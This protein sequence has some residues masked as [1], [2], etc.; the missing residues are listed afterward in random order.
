L[1]QE[2]KIVG[3]AFRVTPLV[4]MSESAQEYLALHKKLV[5]EINPQ[6]PIEAMYVKEVTDLIW[7]I[8]RL[9]DFKIS[10]IILATRRSLVNVLMELLTHHAKIK[11]DKLAKNWFDENEDESAAA[12]EEVHK[13][14]ARFNLDES[15]IEAEA[16]KLV[17]DQLD[18]LDKHLA[19]A[20]SRLDKAL[21]SI[22]SYR[23]DFGND[24]TRQSNRLLDLSAARQAT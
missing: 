18:W 8:Q 13:I 21:R 1:D 20:S 12:K 3:V 5:D 24:L 10:I 15:I 2:Q 22:K 9:R 16:M 19:L 14:L 4:L 6:G 11:V 7:A 17:A 23:A